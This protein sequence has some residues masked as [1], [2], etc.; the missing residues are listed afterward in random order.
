MCFPPY[1]TSHYVN[2]YSRT[3]QHPNQDVSAD[4]ALH[5]NIEHQG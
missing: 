1:D 5:G 3:G 2:C 4:E